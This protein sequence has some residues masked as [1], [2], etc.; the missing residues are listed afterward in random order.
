MAA[1]LR[2]CGCDGRVRD[3]APRRCVR[4]SAELQDITPASGVD[5]WPAWPD[6][7]PTDDANL[8]E[9]QAFIARFIRSQDPWEATST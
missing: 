9:Q 8:A 4:C 1:R 6:E 7:E 2:P 3:D 5:I